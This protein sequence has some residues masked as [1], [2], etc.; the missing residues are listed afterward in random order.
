M[1][2]NDVLTPLCLTQLLWRKGT[3]YFCFSLLS[4][5]PSKMCPL[6]HHVIIFLQILLL[7]HP[8][9]FRLPKQ[10]I[11]GD[12]PI[13][14]MLPSLSRCSYKEITLAG[15]TITLDP[16]NPIPCCLT[17]GWRF[18]KYPLPALP[19]PPHPRSHIYTLNST[20]SWPTHTF[21]YSGFYYQHT[22]DPN[23]P[24]IYLCWILNL[25]P[26]CWDLAGLLQFKTYFPWRHL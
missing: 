22:Y 4:L 11:W 19:A 25:R 26:C 5:L 9:S 21:S 1:T 6:L 24:W 13:F 15:L 23:C 17:L 7:Y 12:S 10:K 2:H 8:F 20:G 16:P 18:E 3:L 14:N